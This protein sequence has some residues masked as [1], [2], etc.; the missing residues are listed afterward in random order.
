[1]HCG[2]ATRAASPHAALRSPSPGQASQPPT[3]LLPTQLLDRSTGRLHWAQLRAQLCQSHTASSGSATAYG[4]PSQESLCCS[5]ACAGHS[6]LCWALRPVPD[7]SPAA[8]H[9]R[10]P[11]AIKAGLGMTLLLTLTLGYKHHPCPTAVSLH[12]K[13]WLPSSTRPQVA[14]WSLGP[15]AQRGLLLLQPGRIQMEGK[16]Q[17]PPSHGSSGVGAGRGCPGAAQ[18]CCHP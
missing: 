18:C 9:L 6:G 15:L 13:M 12:P 14:P 5:E 3:R 7:P 2:G 10:A 4:Y 11:S 16:G 1:M 8:L 17:Q